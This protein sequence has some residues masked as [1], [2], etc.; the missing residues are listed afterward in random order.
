MMSRMRTGIEELDDSSWYQKFATCAS[1]LRAVGMFEMITV[2]DMSLSFYF[3]SNF[4]RTFPWY[5]FFKTA[6]VWQFSII[7]D[8]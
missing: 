1:R 7:R 5:V 4:I 2:D 6:D 3:Y 8:E